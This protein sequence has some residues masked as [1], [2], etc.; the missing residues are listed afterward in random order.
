MAE[1]KRMKLTKITDNN[2]NVAVHVPV[3][4]ASTMRRCNMCDVLANNRRN[5]IVPHSGTRSFTL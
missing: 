1:N 3:L 5:Q 4:T 2:A